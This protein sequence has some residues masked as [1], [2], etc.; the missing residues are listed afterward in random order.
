[1]F[2]RFASIMPFANSRKMLPRDAWF[3]ASIAALQHEDCAPACR[4]A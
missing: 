4:L 1:M 3:V 2:F